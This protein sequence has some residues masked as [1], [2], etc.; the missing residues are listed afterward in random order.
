MVARETAL[1]RTQPIKIGWTTISASCSKSSQHTTRGKTE[2]LKRA[3]FRLAD[4]SSCCLQFNVKCM[5]PGTQS[6]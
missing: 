3:F 5:M 6:V 4:K 2:A 1:I